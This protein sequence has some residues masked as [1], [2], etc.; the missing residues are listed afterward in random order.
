MKPTPDMRVILNFLQQVDKSSTQE[1]A[2]CTSIAEWRVEIDVE[3]M[4]DEEW[5]DISTDSDDNTV[6]AITRTS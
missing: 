3:D 4:A 6:V 5:V 2:F 1:I